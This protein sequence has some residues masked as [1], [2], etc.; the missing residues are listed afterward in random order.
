M[1]W[2]RHM[3]N[4]AK[5]G[6]LRDALYLSCMWASYLTGAERASTVLLEKGS[7]N[8]ELEAYVAACYPYRDSAGIAVHLDRYPEIQRTLSKGIPLECDGSREVNTR[9]EV[10][11]SG[12]RTTTF[13]LLVF[14]EML[15]VLHLRGCCD[16]NPETRQ[17]LEIDGL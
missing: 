4:V 15:G 8:R 9:D 12:Y 17:R 5:R 6:D 2:I 16:L 7:S 13:P 14:G 3:S 10:D 11:T 1:E